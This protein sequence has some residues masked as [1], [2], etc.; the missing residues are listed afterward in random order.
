[1]KKKS[2]LP[3]EEGPQHLVNATHLLKRLLH[4]QT[5]L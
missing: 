4:Q 1:M 3:V 5:G 2:M